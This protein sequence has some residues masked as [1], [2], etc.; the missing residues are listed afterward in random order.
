MVLQDPYM[1]YQQTPVFK[2]ENWEIIIID[3][4]DDSKDGTQFKYLLETVESHIGT[5]AL[6]QFGDSK[7]QFRTYR[8]S[9]K[10]LRSVSK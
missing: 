8:I 6:I 5:K 9:I 2:S 10:V 1:M 4:M 7:R 3:C